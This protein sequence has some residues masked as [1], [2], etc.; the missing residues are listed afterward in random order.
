[1]LH[2]LMQSA[3]IDRI[4]WVLVHSLWQ[5]ALVALLAVVLQRAL[6][7]C[8]AAVRY[9]ALLAAMS[10]LVV[11]PLVTWFSPWAADAPA[12]AVKLR[13]LEESRDVLP[14]LH[15]SPSR[16][17]NHTTAMAAGT[18][19][20]RG[21]TAVKPQAEPLPSERAA[22]DPIST[23]S[24]VKQ[25]VQPWLTQIV[26]VWFAGVFLS[27]FRPLLG[28]HTVR[29]LRTVGVSPVPDAVHA[30]MDRVTK[31]LRLARAVELLQ[32]ALVKT[33]AVV[34]CFRP[35][36]LLPLCVVTRLPEAQLELILAHELAHIRRHDY[37]VN[38]LQALVETLFFYHPAVWWL[39]RQIRNE[40]ENCCDDVAMATGGSRADYGRALLAVAELRA[41][42]PGLSL[43]AGGG[44][45]LARIR[46]IAGC[47]PAPRVTGGGVLCLILVSLA[48]CAAVTWGA[49]PAV[50]ELGQA[51]AQAVVAGQVVDSTGKPLSGAQ[52]GVVARSKK[53]LAG[54]NLYQPGSDL[55]VLG[56]AKTDAHGYFRIPVQPLSSAAFW[57]A[58][59]LATA[60]GYAPAAQP[61]GLDHEQCDTLVSLAAEQLL[62]GRVVDSKGQPAANARMIVLGREGSIAEVAPMTGW[63]EPVTT[64]DQGRFTIHGVNTDR[65]AFVEVADE[66]FARWHF[67]IGRP[68]AGMTAAE[69]RKKYPYVFVGEEFVAQK[70]P[71]EEV[72]LVPPASQIIEGR[73][74]YDDSKKPVPFARLNVDAG[75]WKPAP[76][77]QPTAR[78]TRRASSASTRTPATISMSRRIHPA[79]SRILSP[80]NRW[81]GARRIPSGRSRLPCRAIMPFWSGGRS[82][83]ILRENRSAGQ[84]YNTKPSTRL[85]GLSPVGKAWC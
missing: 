67:Y 27:A 12:A 65:G 75:R 15:V 70:D 77:L 80:K 2:L 5:F 14:P 44:S 49:A 63:P 3:W 55:K 66:R 56:A 8:S 41:A 36:I 68:G 29:R 25:Y 38:L 58:H 17:G 4:G 57:E 10:T 21:E 7:R 42:V 11:V 18:S 13:P 33:P 24:R 28:W 26:L 48:I 79:A 20:F 85:R 31:R 60:S 6:G 19:E 22:T 30:V 78:R 62:R 43:A 40:R 47:E 32:S 76:G 54:G 35:A 39:S 1:M 37:L 46:R 45:L 23:W 9:R 71:A 53:P 84:A 83:R 16:P 69:V 81:L 82:L 51:T 52:V 73:V 74:V 61:L 72:T 64:D 34:G 50:E 59:V